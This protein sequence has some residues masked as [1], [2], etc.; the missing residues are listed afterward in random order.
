MW[1]EKKNLA[2]E[3]PGHVTGSLQVKTAHRVWTTEE[4]EFFS[5]FL[6]V[7]K[8]KMRTISLDNGQKLQSVS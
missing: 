4:T 1:Q 7:T 2:M 5:F 8:E 6:R 3:A